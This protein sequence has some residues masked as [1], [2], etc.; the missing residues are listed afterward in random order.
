M[1]VTVGCLAASCI[2][3]SCIAAP[4]RMV[5]RYIYGIF[6]LLCNLLAWMARD[7]GSSSKNLN[8]ALVHCKSDSNLLPVFTVFCFLQICSR[9]LSDY[10]FVGS[11]DCLLCQIASSRR[12]CLSVQIEKECSATLSKFHKI[13]FLHDSWVDYV[14]ARIFRWW[15][16]C[17]KCSRLEISL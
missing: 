15:C 8:R 9:L 17:K 14:H 6:F 7:Y 3:R 16:M 5:A 11:L 1:C 12:F 13:W 4:N 2:C 10:Q